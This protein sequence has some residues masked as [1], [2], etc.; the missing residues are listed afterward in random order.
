MTEHQNLANFEAHLN[1]TGPEIWRQTSG[2]ID[3]FVAGAGRS[4]PMSHCGAS[5]SR[6]S[7]WTCQARVA[8]WPV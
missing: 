8:L 4:Q 7:H 5:L 2:G 1:G 3:A 6:L